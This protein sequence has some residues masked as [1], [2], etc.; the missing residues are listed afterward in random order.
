MRRLSAP[1]AAMRAGF[2]HLWPVLTAAIAMI[3]ALV[4][5]NAAARA[6]PPGTV[7]IYFFWG[8]G[9]PHCVEARPVVEA[10]AEQYPGAEL[11]TYEVYDSR[12]NAALLNRMAD[13]M[14][15]GIVAVPTI[16]IG[17]RYWIGYTNSLAAQVE[18][19]LAACLR[20]DCP[21]PGAAA[22]AGIGGDI[23]AETRGS[24]APQPARIDL[25]L[26]GAVDFA[27]KS[28]W[29]STALIAFVDG[30]NPCSL[31]VLSILV[32]LTLHTGSRKKVLIIGLTFITVTAGVYALF[33]AGL[34]TVL[35][36][37]SFADPIRLGVALIAAFFG[38]VNIKD[39]FFFRE[40]LSFTIDESGKRKIMQGMRRVIDASESV[41]G[42]IAATVL[43]A[44]G[45]SMVEFSCTAGFPVIWT[46]LLAANAVPALTFALLL[47]L[48]LVIYQIDEFA[49]FLT[50]VFTLRA[51]RLQERQ[52]RIL[53]LIGGVLMLTLAGV[54]AFDPALMSGIGSSI[55]IF[56]V[57]FA[58]SAV[59]LIVHRR[60]LP[61]FGIR[62]GTENTTG[63][64]D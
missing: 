18:P 33:I 39:Y 8:E 57:A 19:V 50:A 23:D 62:I 28:L 34:F 27:D 61:R 13:A 40:G 21:D 59:V 45:V 35:S 7:A 24:A 64:R 60:I 51:S 46:D 49:I 2:D 20:D 12:E 52:G 56:A 3:A 41:G 63:A 55:A 6:E 15:F 43:L 4:V 17:D 36:V 44:V 11:R 47:L 1:R 58:I 37:A 54:M 29:L 42:L 16:V 14:G 53:K 38:A 48:Y 32:A 25:P 26:I 31:W 22:I 5:S 30:F 9:C 10:L